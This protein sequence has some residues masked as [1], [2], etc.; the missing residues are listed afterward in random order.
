MIRAGLIVNPVAGV[1]GPKGLRGSDGELAGRALRNGARQ[2]SGQR[3][4]QAMASLAEAMHDEGMELPEILTCGGA[5]GEDA[6]KGAHYG[7]YTVVYNAPRNTTARDTVAAAG[8]IKERGADIIVFCGGDGTAR[9]VV[10]GAG[11]DF[12][13]LGIPAGVKMYTGLFLGRPCELGRSML[14]IMANGLK[15]K[16]VYLLDF[17]KTDGKEGTGV[18]R[19]GDAAVPLLRSVQQ[20]KSESPGP[21]EELEGISDYFLESISSEAYYVM[22]TGSTVKFILR[23]LGYNTPVLGVDIMKGRE[24]VGMDVTDDMLDAL[25]HNAAGHELFVVVTPLGGNGFIFGRGNQQISASF[26]SSVG[27]ERVIVVATTEKMNMLR[28]LRVDTGDPGLDSALRGPIEVLTGYATRRISE[29][30]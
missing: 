13:I 22:S 21:G 4:Q 17:A 25:L 30:V 12:P 19:Y 24:L 23:K 15:T 28:T 8:L 14:E 1:G 5:M 27:R 6:L 16:H 10:E 29:V 26:I 9:D 3:A 2:K 11:S 18:E 7:N 20:A